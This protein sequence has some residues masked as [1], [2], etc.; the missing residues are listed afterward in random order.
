[1]SIMMIRIYIQCARVKDDR[2]FS[3][4][5]NWS[6]WIMQRK[7]KGIFFKYYRKKNINIIEYT[8]I[9]SDIV[10]GHILKYIYRYVYA[11]VCV[12]LN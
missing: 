11:Y 12:L 3:F 10:K 8:D 2:S 4:A 9:V 5:S 7:Q 6:N 1:M